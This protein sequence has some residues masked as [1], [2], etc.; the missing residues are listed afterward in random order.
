MLRWSKYFYLTT[1]PSHEEL[2]W[3]RLEPSYADFVAAVNRRTKLCTASG[4]GAKQENARIFAMSEKFKLPGVLGFKASNLKTTEK[5][6]GPMSNQVMTAATAFLASITE[7]STV[8]KAW[9]GTSAHALT[10]CV[11]KIATVS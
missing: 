1:V 9:A 3:D 2:E 11:S 4:Q 10:T 5:N 8:D 7:P 6:A